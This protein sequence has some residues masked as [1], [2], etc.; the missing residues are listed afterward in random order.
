MESNKSY[1][2]NERERKREMLLSAKVI[3]AGLSTIGLSGAGIG[4]GLVFSALISSTSRNPSVK[5]DLFTYAIL[6]FGAALRDIC[7]IFS[8]RYDHRDL[9]QQTGSL[10]IVES[11]VGGIAVPISVDLLDEYSVHRSAAENEEGPKDTNAEREHITSNNNGAERSGANENTRTTGNR[12]TDIGRGIST[13]GGKPQE[14]EIDGINNPMVNNSGGSEGP[15]QGEP[16]NPR[17]KK[18]TDLE[19][20]TI[21]ELKAGRWPAEDPKLK[22]EL[23]RYIQSERRRTAVE[24]ARLREGKV[25]LTGKDENDS[26]GFQGE[27]RKEILVEL[28]REASTRMKSVLWRVMAIELLSKNTGST[29]P[30]VDGEKLEAIPGEAKDNERARRILKEKIEELKT[31]ES[32]AK[33]R[34][35]QAIRRKGIEGLT[36]RE[37][38]RREM[39]AER[40]QRM[41]RREELKEMEE[42]PV[43]KVREQR[44]EIKN[45]NRELKLKWEKEIG[46]LG[47]RTGREKYKPD[48]IKRVYIEKL[49]GK[50]RL[51]G[52]PTMRD[53]SVQML[54]KLV[55][56]P[57]MEPWGDSTSFG[58][59]PGRNCNQAISYL[60]NRL[61]YYRRGGLERMRMRTKR[62]APSTKERQVER[63]FPIKGILDCD[64]KGCFDNIDHGW[65]MRNVPIPIGYTE[66]FEK[67][68]KAPIQTEENRLEVGEKGIPQGGIISPMLMNWTLDGLEEEV[69]ETVK[70][71]RSTT[72]KWKGWL[73]VEGKEEH[74]GVG[75]PTHSTM[76]KHSRKQGKL[77]EENM[78]NKHDIERRTGSRGTAWM[79]RYADDII[80]G[81]NSVE[82]MKPIK[83]RI[84]KFLEERGLELSE[85]KTRAME[86][87]IGGKLEFL[88][89]TFHLVKPIKKNWIIKAP[90]VAR[91]RLRDWLGLYVYPSRGATSRLRG[92]VKEITSIK[93]T[94]KDVM[95][96]VKELTLYLLGWSEYYRPG[97]KQ[98]KL[99]LG[100][101]NYIY[102]CCKRF[103]YKKYQ[104]VSMREIVDRHFK[105][106]GKWRGLHVK[107]ERG[108]IRGEVPRLW[109]YAA[110]A[111]W[112]S[113]EVARELLKN[114][115]L[116]NPIP[117]MRR[118]IQIGK[119]KGSVQAE[120]MKEQKN[121][122]PVC[123]E[124]LVNW[125]LAMGEP[126]LM[127]V[128]GTGE[129]AK[130]EEK[131]RRFKNP[132]DVDTEIR[133]NKG[134]EM[135]HIIPKGIGVTKEIREILEHRKNKRLIHKECHRS[136][137]GEDKSLI[138]GVKEEYKRLARMENDKGAAMAALKKEEG[139][140]KGRNKAIW[141][142]IKK[143]C[144]E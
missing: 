79:I 140:I 134:L 104:R 128:I 100:I 15:R 71:Y 119:L 91:G 30:G 78:R 132:E 64:I 57:I 14:G 112:T 67:I 136:K 73:K 107:D 137:Y 76:L 83:G 23:V 26:K 18:K 77:E 117:Y 82:Y 75:K 102:R 123:G 24:S 27:L 35:D 89:W 58:F 1:A 11:E 53:R 32:R 70:N 120:K 99:R 10:G 133:W 131:S 62:R 38:E 101:D 13:E 86:W 9:P 4:I 87:K 22:E 96:I 115:A 7:G 130:K 55:M 114:S 88:S 125:G 33:G 106:E 84:R 28:R 127:N 29:N 141:N 46:E 143:A 42:R 56:E 138:R 36:G 110:E 121:K 93:N 39:K 40:E 52:I 92:E 90:R 81:A 59:R 51:L 8:G 60:A 3:G 85:E 68:L 109:K 2:S 6:G 37:K 105:A 49:N 16:E 54:M 80:V 12:Q 94:N 72:H 50:L 118:E 103:L 34:T 5:S 25:G 135:D 43:Q 108:T 95:T 116:V 98:T 17:D 61:E 20:R 122:C 65:L 41:R 113:L 126:E 124:E 129:K 144:K 19:R 97:G 66:T 139:I 31:K 111:S 63:Y 69:K 74:A 142:R 45:R 48:P 47:R 44:E 21:T